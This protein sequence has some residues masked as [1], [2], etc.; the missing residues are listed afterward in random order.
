[1][2]L[3]GIPS[4]MKLLTVVFAF[5]SGSL[6]FLT[7]GVILAIRERTTHPD[8]YPMPS[9]PTAR[10]VAYLTIAISLQLLSACLLMA[11]SAEKGSIY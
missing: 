11:T 4:M 2:S 10:I 8:W 6:L 1:M 3:S 7:Q 9:H 5:V